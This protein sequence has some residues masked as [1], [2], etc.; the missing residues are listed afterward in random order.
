MVVHANSVIMDSDLSTPAVLKF[1]YHAEVLTLDIGIALITAQPKE[2]G[3]TEE[4][5]FST[6][7][8]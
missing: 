4:T 5:T 6:P 2:N 3:H 8:P 1:A 7:L